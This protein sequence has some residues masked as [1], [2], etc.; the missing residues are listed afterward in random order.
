MTCILHDKE[1]L[2]DGLYAS[3]DG[4]HIILSCERNGQEHWI[5]LEHPVLEAFD[6]YRKRLYDAIILYKRF[7]D[8]KK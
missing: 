4:Y 2:G 7:Q 1:Y 6:D 3:F 5:A 8:E